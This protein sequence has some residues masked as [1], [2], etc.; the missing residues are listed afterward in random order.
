MACDEYPEF[1][2]PVLWAVNIWAYFLHKPPPEG[3]GGRQTLEYGP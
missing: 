2:R 1:Y 3:F